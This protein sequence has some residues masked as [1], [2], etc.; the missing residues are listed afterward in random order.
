MDIAATLRR[1]D[2][3]RV[4]PFRAVAEAVQDAPESVMGELLDLAASD[5]MELQVGATWVLKRLAERGTAPRGPQGQELLR[6][7]GRPL[8]PDALLHVLQT[9]PHLEIGSAPQGTLRD[10][11]LA[12]IRHRRA[13]IRAWAY[14][15]LGI[16]A[17]RDPS[18]RREALTLMDRAAR[19]ETAAVKARIRQARAAIPR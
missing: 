7:L 3:K 15:G 8:A 2:G 14:N 12:L 13:F 17:E 16:L 1:Y 11:L 9:L 18:F 4:A 6:L 19:N 5:E 10:A